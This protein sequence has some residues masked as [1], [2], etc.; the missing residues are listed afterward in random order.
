MLFRLSYGYQNK[1]ILHA[2]NTEETSIW[3]DLHEILFFSTAKTDGYIF[4]Q[5]LTPETTYRTRFK[6]LLTPCFSEVKILPKHAKG[7]P[8][9]P[10]ETV[11]KKSCRV[12]NMSS[13]T[14]CSTTSLF[15]PSKRTPVTFSLRYRLAGAPC[16]AALRGMGV[17][18]TWPF[19][20]RVGVAVRLGTEVGIAEGGWAV[21]DG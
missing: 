19:V 12:G 3:I 13:Y 20:F 8:A 1:P 6:C 2:L 14:H 18:S 9:Y 7:L 17:V 15:I 11:K 10:M 4:N 16:A 5:P 21:G